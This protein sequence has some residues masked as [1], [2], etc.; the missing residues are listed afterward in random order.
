LVIG[1]QIQPQY[2]RLGMNRFQNRCL[3]CRIADV[4]NC[5]FHFLA[6]ATPPVLGGRALLSVALSARKSSNATLAATRRRPLRSSPAHGNVRTMKRENLMELHP[7]DSS[8]P[9]ASLSG[10]ENPPTQGADLLACILPPMWLCRSCTP[11][12]SS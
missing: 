8:F 4:D 9:D 10:R 6:G 12:V 2:D 5:T 7:P 11:I 3:G 1:L